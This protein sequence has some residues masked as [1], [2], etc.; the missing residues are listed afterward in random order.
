MRHQPKCDIC[1][2]DGNIK[3]LWTSNRYPMPICRVCLGEL[4]AY[5]ADMKADYSERVS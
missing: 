4:E 2:D 1:N 5:I 3:Y